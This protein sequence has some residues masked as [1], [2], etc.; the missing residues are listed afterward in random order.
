MWGVHFCECKRQADDDKLL[1][2]HQGDSRIRTD[3][4]ITFLITYNRKTLENQGFFK[5]LT[6]I[7]T[8]FGSRKLIKSRRNAHCLQCVY[9]PEIFI[10]LSISQLIYPSSHPKQQKFYR[11][12][13]QKNCTRLFHFLS[14]L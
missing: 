6:G 3:I 7:G 10:G 5:L 9:N 13:L 12:S 8:L 1:D 11:K 2:N 4:L 14:V